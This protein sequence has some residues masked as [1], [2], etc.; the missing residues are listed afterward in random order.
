MELETSVLKLFG[1]VKEIPG[2]VLHHCPLPV[3]LMANK[4]SFKPQMLSLEEAIMLGFSKNS[5]V[6]VSLVEQT[7]SIA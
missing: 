4:E 5:T 3:P 1:L 7:E 2:D 6:R